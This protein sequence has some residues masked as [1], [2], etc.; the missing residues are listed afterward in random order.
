[1]SIDLMDE[2]MGADATCDASAAEKAAKFAGMVPP[3]EYQAVLHTATEKDLRDSKIIE[4]EFKLV[5]GPAKG[6]KVRYT[7][8]MGVKETDKNGVPRSPEEIEQAKNSI[9]NNF[10]TTAAA[11]GLAK[12]VTKDGKASFVKAE[13]KYNFRDCCD[14]ECVV[15]TKI[16]EYVDARS[17]EKKQT[18]EVA[19]FGV[20]PLG[21]RKP[22]AGSTVTEKAPDLADIF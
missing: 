6:M 18:S 3:G 9:K 19:M 2:L 17:G 12:K 22:L 8:F 1:M 10:W 16:R 7:L 21:D 20:L 14:T 13:G 4:L 5:S 11:V 15:K